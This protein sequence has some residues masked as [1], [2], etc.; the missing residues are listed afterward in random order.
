MAF[1]LS[2]PYPDDPS[3]QLRAGGLDKSQFTVDW[4]RKVVTCPAGKQSI[5]WL[6]QRYP[7]S[8]YTWEVRFASKDCKPCA[9]RTGCTKSKQDPRRINL[10]IQEQHEALQRVRL[11]QQTET[12]RLQYAARAGIEGTHEQALRRCGLRDSRYIGQAKTRL[13]HIITAAAIN[14]IRIN[15]WW[16]SNPKAPTRR[17][18]F[19]ALEHIPVAA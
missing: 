8:G 3:W 6:P 14:L 9:L 16:M 12:F 18:R 13:Q 2:D 7:K 4:E 19:A 17:S 10:Q 15:E 1:E 11:E 5:S